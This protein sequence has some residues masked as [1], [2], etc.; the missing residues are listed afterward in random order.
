[1]VLLVDKTFGN[2]IS[3]TKGFVNEISLIKGP[4]VAKMEFF[5]SL[6]LGKELLTILSDFY[7]IVRHARVNFPIC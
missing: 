7:Y 4:M 1:M 3:L 6:L 5:R 2:E